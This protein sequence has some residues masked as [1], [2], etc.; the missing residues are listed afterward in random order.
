MVGLKA[1][2]RNDEEMKENLAKR[3]L[4]KIKSFIKKHKIPSLMIQ[5]LGSIAVSLFVNRET[6]MLFTRLL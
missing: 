1:D 6:A 2:L 3:N 5:A 4:V